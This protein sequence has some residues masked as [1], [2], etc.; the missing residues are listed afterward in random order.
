MSSVFSISGLNAGYGKTKIL[1]EAS[2]TIEDKSLTV[3][4]GAVGSGKSTLLSIISGTSQGWSEWELAFLA[5]TPLGDGNW[6]P[7]LGQAALK[8]PPA[9]RLAA[10][11]DFLSSPGHLLCLDEPTAG[12][13]GHYETSILEAIYKAAKDRAILIVTHNLTS[14]REFA[15]HIAILAS[16]RIVEQSSAQDFFAGPSTPAGQAFMETGS[17]SEPSAMA[18]GYE[19]S[20]EFRP[21]PKAIDLAPRERNPGLIDW[22]ILDQ[23][24]IADRKQD[25]NKLKV[26]PKTTHVILDA[27]LDSAKGEDAVKVVRWDSQATDHLARLEFICERCL[28]QIDQGH[29]VVLHSDPQNA[30]AL[31]AAAAL[32]VIKGTTAIDAIAAVTYRTR[33][34][35]MT[36]EEEQIVW[37]FELRLDLQKEAEDR[38]D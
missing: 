36:L 20:P 17:N 22:I 32:L 1:S 10:I 24:G 30:K 11:Q 33:G 13:F 27:E 16:G 35:P 26:E 7:V 23:L 28:G 25:L 5:G 21:F 19:L 18:H 31:V 37:D 4:A 15:D 14:V 29:T 9:E 2:L 34:K 8:L 6:V 12:V 3:L 38:A